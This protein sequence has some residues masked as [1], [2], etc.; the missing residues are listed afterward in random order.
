MKFFHLSDLHIG[1]KLINRDLREDQEYILRQITDI[2]VREQPDGIV[3]AGDIYDKAVPSAEAVEVFDGFIAGLAAALPDTA[4]MLISGNHDSGPRVNCFRSVLSRQNFHMIGLPPRRE[5]EFIEKV[6]LSDEHGPVNFYLL[7]FV[8]PSMVKQLVGTDENGNNL[9]YNETLRRLIGREEINEAE[10]NVLVS[11]QFYLPA[12]K[13]ADEVE[14]MDSEMR[15]V[16]N[17]DEVSADILERFDYAALGH[18]H[19]PMKVGSESFRYCG[20]PLACSV[21]EAEQQKGIIMVEMEEKGDLRTTVLPLEPLRQVRVIRGELSEV[22]E[23]ACGDYVTVI[24][25]DRADLDIFDMQDRIRNA[26]PYLLEIR[27]ETLRTADYSRGTAVQEELD[28]FALCC[29]FLKDADEGEKEI[30]RDVI[31]AV[32]EVEQG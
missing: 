29:S 14:R 12:G 15:T 1:L 26:F 20:T 17:I 2:A 19:K 6:T 21:S 28:P 9:S 10:R 4:V 16:G 13:N 8:K 11:H 5:G 23:Q 3:I 31:N 7:P 32:Q 18:I 30:L 24:L 27:R 22:L 25:T